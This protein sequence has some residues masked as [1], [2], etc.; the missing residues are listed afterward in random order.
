MTA[1]LGDY[2][3]NTITA[4]NLQSQ[5]IKIEEWA[6]NCKRK[7]I[8]EEFFYVNFT[9]KKEKSPILQFEGMAIPIETQLKYLGLILDKR[10]TRDFH[11]KATRKKL[12]SR[13]HLFC[14]ILKSNLSLNNKSSQRKT[15]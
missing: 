3:N 1:I 4:S 9:L 13:L 12:I 6:S 15:L 7:I 10:L 5:L 14:P 8:V 2:S 11:L